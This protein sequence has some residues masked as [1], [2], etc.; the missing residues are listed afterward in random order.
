MDYAFRRTGLN[1][2][3]DPHA[4]EI[5]ELRRESWVCTL[6]CS[7][8]DRGNH[9]RVANDTDVQDKSGRREVV[10]CQYPISFAFQLWQ[11]L[12]IQVSHF[13]EP[14]LFARD[15]NDGR[16]KILFRL[17]F[18]WSILLECHCDLWRNLCRET[19]RAASTYA[20][21]NTCK[22]RRHPLDTGNLLIAN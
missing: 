19:T 22:P 10:P 6:F 3:S 13:Y 21:P 15:F 9:Q 16:L 11:Y 17:K 5:T 1:C 20:N 18:L 14:E 7:D 8:D 2:S 12:S 4:T